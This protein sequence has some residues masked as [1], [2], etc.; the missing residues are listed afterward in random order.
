MRNPP[1]SKP[2]P[3]GLHF[4]TDWKILLDLG[5]ATYVFPSFLSNTLERLDFCIF[6]GQSH[7]VILV[8][9]TRPREENMENW[10]RMKSEKYATL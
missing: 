4:A 7:R 6:S 1:K 2:S 9:L 5:T 3:F 8:E 10:N